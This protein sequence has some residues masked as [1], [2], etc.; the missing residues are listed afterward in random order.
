MKKNDIELLDLNDEQEAYSPEPLSRKERNRQKKEKKKEKKRKKR[1][2]REFAVATYTILLLLLCVC[3]HFAYF[4]T[5]ES[6]DFISSSYNKRLGSLSEHTVR[7]NIYTRDG[8]LLATSSVSS[9]GSEY[10]SYPQGRKYAHAV[11]FNTNGM[12]GVEKDAHF[13]LLRSHSFFLYRLKNE[14][15]GKK[16][17]GDSVVTTLDSTLQDIAYNKM[18]H[19]NGAVVAIDPDSG[20]ILSMVSKGDF[21]PNTIANNWDS[22]TSDGESSVL[23]N[24]ATQGLYPPGSTFKIVTALE[25]INEGGKAEDLYD[26]TGSYEAGGFEIHDYKNKSHGEQTFM[27]AFAHSCNSTFAKVGLTLSKAKLTK[28]TDRLLF[29]RK[30]PTSLSISNKSRFGVD[31]HTPDA[32]MMQ[33]AIGQGDTLVTPMHM[34]MIASAIANDGILMRPY[35]ADEI[36]N[37]AGAHVKSFHNLPA[38]RILSKEEA[39]VMQEYMRY[40]VTD[41]TGSKLNGDAYTAYGKTGTAEFNAKKEAHSWFVGYATAGEKKIAV[42]IIL[43]GA[44]AGSEYA[45]PLAKDLFDAYCR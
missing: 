31:R 23:V 35:I 10:R 38:G 41:G 29:N 27:E 40:V 13:Y 11:G 25:Y 24:R 28:L 7:G 2:N 3:V 8:V 16:N 5:F 33:T 21:D 36:V 42:A 43:E 18:G 20:K 12:A 22:L 1:A 4:L 44:G 45:V 34:A 6:E 32:L 14:I 39:A 30:L 37:D 9:D 19:Y 15:E 26:C 17:Q